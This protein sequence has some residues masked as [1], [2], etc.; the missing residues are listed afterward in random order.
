MKSISLFVITI[1]FMAQTSNNKRDFVDISTL[2]TT[3]LYD[4]KYAT[5]DNFL[6]EKVYDCDACVIRN[7]VAEA[8]I[9]ANKEL[10]TKGY[11]IKFFD[12]YRPLDVQKKMW[13][14]YPNAK[15][16]AN[17]YKNGSSHNRGGAVD[18]TLCTLD[19]KELDM[20]TSFDHFGEEAHHAYTKLDKQVLENR[21][22]LKTTMEKHGFTA[23][24]TEWWHYNYKNASSYGL[25][26]FTTECK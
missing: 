12:C 9:A 15:Y 23:I 20:G 21:K 26:N 18:I 8:L 24:R 16:V 6:K 10:I 2:S 1:L 13:K 3:F 7:E 14:I 25:S 19:G 4:M 22:L 11:K 17:P 5:T